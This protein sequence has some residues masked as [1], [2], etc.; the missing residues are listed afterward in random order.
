MKVIARIGRLMGGIVAFRQDL[1]A[2]RKQ[3]V[4]QALLTLHEDQEGRQM[5]MLFQLSRLTP[6]L[7]ESLARIEALYAEH[8]SLRT[9]LVKR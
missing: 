5:F 7:P 3:K 8:Q 4:R 1:P 6:F 9:K 2:E